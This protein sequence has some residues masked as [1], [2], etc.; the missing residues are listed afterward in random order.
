MNFMTPRLYAIASMVKKGANVIDVGTDHA[1][2]PLYL[3]EK[4][5][6]GRILATDVK[7]GPLSRA[8]ANIRKFGADNIVATALSDGL[9]SLDTKGFDT[10]IIA[11]MGGL[12]IADIMKRA[13]FKGTYI[14]QPMSGIE[15]LRH[16]LFT[17]GYN[18]L[19]EKLVMEGKKMYTVMSVRAGRKEKFLE[20]ELYLGKKLR[21]D[22]LYPE[23][24]LRQK[25]KIEKVVK[26]LNSA[27][28]VDKAA[29]EYYNKILGQMEGAISDYKN[30]R[31][32]D[33]YRQG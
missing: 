18:V 20:I 17:N 7:K 26:G 10:V 15:E 8:E 16:F 9:C 14:L 2:I 1:Y 11:G 12:V 24:L 5:I 28:R 31:R 27:G 32:Q 3:A 23:F 21:D 29:V 13:D 6:S 4:K 30:N 22:G 19:E 33:N 25:E